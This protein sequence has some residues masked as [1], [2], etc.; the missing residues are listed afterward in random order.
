MILAQANLDASI[1]TLLSRVGQTYEL[2]LENKS[3][4]KINAT[5]DILVQIAQ[6]IRECATFISQYSE[7]KSFCR[8]PRLSLPFQEFISFTGLRLRKNVLKET[9]TKVANYNSKLNQ[10]MQDLRDL[11]LLDV[12]VGVQ[13]IREDFSLESLV[14]A[15][16]VGLIKGKKCLDGTRT[17]ILTEILDWMNSTDPATPPILWLHG[18]A[19]RGKSAIAH[20]IALQA[21]NLGVLGSCFCFSRTRHHEGLHVKLF[22]TI[23]RDL[24]D[25][26]LR[27]HQILAEVISND[28]SLRDTADIAEQWKKF[29][30][31]PFSQLEGTLSRNIV[32]VIDALDE[33]GAEATRRDILDILAHGAQLPSN[34]RIVLTSRPIMDIRQA[35]LVS[36]H[37][38]AKSLD[39]IEADSATRDITHYISTTL[40]KVGAAFSDKDLEQ[41]AAK[42]N[43]LFEWAR[44][45][46]D[47]L[48]PRIGVIANERFRKIMSHAGDGANL[49]DGIYTMSLK[50]LIQGDADVLERFRS[51]MRQILWSKEPLSINALDSMRCKFT[52]EDDHFPVG[53]ILG[54]MASFLTGTTD[55]STPVRPLHA[56]FYDF[57]LDKRRS[58]GFFIDE[59]DVHRELALASL[60]VMRDGLRFNICGLETSYVRN[61]AVADLQIKIEKNIPLHLLYSCR[62]W[63]T[64]LHDSTFDTDLAKHVMDIVT[65]ER[66]LFWMEVLGVCKCIGEADRALTSAEGWLQVSILYY[67]S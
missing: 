18:Q 29:I 1:A 13:Q 51:V 41:L 34:I 64:H 26:D 15:G 56:S 24:A 44:L 61:S 38:Q 39:D 25:C 23:A 16:Q 4:S 50:D 9:D 35:L 32:V 20:T 48:C 45:A 60:C 57:L 3:S 63:A 30:L 17:E 5:K 11:T 58:D 22:A 37:V 8:P 33:S 43:G 67:T 59:T 12:Q 2:I 55:P 19:G 14:C 21:Q 52:R 36:H 31:E 46:C 42:S 40:K 10:L 47:F 66:I 28:H 53:I 65:G 6:I 49:L 62:F 7:T 27:L 54:Y